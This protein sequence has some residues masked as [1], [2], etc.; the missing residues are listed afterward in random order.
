MKKTYSAPILSQKST[1][2]LLL[3]VPSNVTGDNG[4]GSGPVDNGDGGDPD[5]KQR[6]GSDAWGSLW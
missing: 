2:G 5:A 3:L 1:D 6:D 4:T